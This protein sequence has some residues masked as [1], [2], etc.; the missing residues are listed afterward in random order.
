MEK[1][2]LCSHA[3]PHSYLSKSHWA[4]KHAEI[5]HAIA[6]DT[7]K[8]K[9]LK[10]TNREICWLLGEGKGS[11]EGRGNGEGKQKNKPQ[12]IAFLLLEPQKINND[13]D[14]YSN[15]PEIKILLLCCKQSS[16]IMECVQA[17]LQYEPQ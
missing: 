11:H 13:D 14:K 12:Q 16:K 17:L 4:C 3:C 9:R 5:I 15:K 8:I 2:L 10:K 7:K 6:A 1:Q